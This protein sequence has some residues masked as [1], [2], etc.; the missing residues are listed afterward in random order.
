[1]IANNEF[2]ISNRGEKIPGKLYSFRGKPERLSIYH[3]MGVDLVTLANNHVYD[4]GASA[5]EDLLTSLNDYHIPYI[6][7]GKNLDEAMKPYYF[8]LN[9]YKFAFVN[10][11]RAEKNILTPGATEDTSGV[12]RCYDPTNLIN[13]IKEV[14]QDSDYVVT[15]IHWGKEDSHELEDVQKE[16]SK[17]YIDAGSDIIVGTHAHMLQGI[18]FYNNKPIIYNIGD[19]IFNNE[20]K[21]TGIF[22]MKL[23]NDGTFDYYFIPALQ[24]DE[25]TSLLKDKEKQRV[26]DDMNNWSIN[27]TIDS[28]G[29]IKEKAQ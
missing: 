18:E 6:G 2:T 10:A 16:T 5:F 21:D 14:K 28:E 1:M 26:I 19:F 12:F 7:A 22:Q 24:K 15:L 27:A 17:M 13:L 11:T 4:F 29:K 25:Y 3:E 8:V 9:G 23:S 20:V